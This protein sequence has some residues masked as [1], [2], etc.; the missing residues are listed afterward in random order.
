LRILRARKNVSEMW[1]EVRP[2]EFIQVGFERKK[3]HG[4]KT[5]E[6]TRDARPKVGGGGVGSLKTRKNVHPS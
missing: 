5:S 1:G 2:P 4:K 6:K 3:E